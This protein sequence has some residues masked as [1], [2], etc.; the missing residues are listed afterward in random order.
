[1]RRARVLRDELVAGRQMAEGFLRALA[2]DRLEVHSA[3]T[4]A[5]RCIPWPSG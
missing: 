2:G 1:V 4:E 3:G 5:S